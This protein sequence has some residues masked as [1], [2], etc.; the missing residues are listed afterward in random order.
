MV[1]DS[2]VIIRFIVE[3]NRKQFLKASEFILKVESRTEKAELS[4]LVMD[5]IIFILQNY[6][7]LQRSD[8]MPKL[9]QLLSMPNF[10][11][12]ETKKEIISEI[13]EKMVGNKIDFTDYYLAAIAPKNQI[14]SFDGDFGKIQTKL[15][16]K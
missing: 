9:L 11:V 15:V 8:F 6:Y 4:I 3:D 2:N 7:H 1:V 13:L 14:F 5:E 16:K 12:L 10:D